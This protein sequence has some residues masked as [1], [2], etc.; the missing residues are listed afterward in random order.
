MP[1]WPLCRARVRQLRARVGPPALTTQPQRACGAAPTGRGP[2]RPPPPHWG[3]AATEQPRRFADQA[4]ARFL[5]KR[6]WELGR[7]GERWRDERTRRGCEGKKGQLGRAAR[8]LLG[9]Y[10]WALVGK[11]ISARWPAKQPSYARWTSSS[12]TRYLR[13][14][15]PR[16]ISSMVEN[17]SEG[18]KG[19]SRGFQR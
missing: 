19:G 8:A 16:I 18:A 15:D 12:T 5:S 1:A 17:F 14:S 2:I 3:Q 9:F 10:I 6:E 13:G 11:E 7:E 4:D